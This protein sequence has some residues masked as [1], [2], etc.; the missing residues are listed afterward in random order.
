MTSRPICLLPVVTPLA[1]TPDSTGFASLTTVTANLASQRINSEATETQVKAALELLAG[2]DLGSFN[3]LEII[4]NGDANGLA[5][6]AWIIMVQNT[7]VPT[8]K[9]IDWVSE[10]PLT[11]LANAA[12]AAAHRYRKL[13]LPLT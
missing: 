8:A 4:A 1:S 5:V 10:V 9:L 11:Q 12:R 7:I 3:P 2:V 13:A 6:F